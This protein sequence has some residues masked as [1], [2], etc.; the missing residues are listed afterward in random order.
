MPRS[1][2][3]SDKYAPILKEA[4]KATILNGIISVAAR[5]AEGHGASDQAKNKFAS[6]LKFL[7]VLS[8]LIALL[9][10]NCGL[11]PAPEAGPRC[12]K[13]RFSWHCRCENRKNVWSPHE[14]CC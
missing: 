5:Q 9:S 12:D 8:L 1:S 2:R 4:K 14:V 11:I 13:G 7:R 6:V 10:K 3:L